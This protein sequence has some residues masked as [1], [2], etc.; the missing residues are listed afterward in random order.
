MGLNITSH[1]SDSE[2]LNILD[3]MDLMW[4]QKNDKISSKPENFVKKCSIRN[5]PRSMKAVSKITWRL[6]AHSFTEVTHKQECCLV[7]AKSIFSIS[8]VSSSTRFDINLIHEIICYS[9]IIFLKSRTRAY[10]AS[11][12]STRSRFY[13]LKTGPSGHSFHQDPVQVP[14][15]GACF[16]LLLE[17]VTSEI[18]GTGRLYVLQSNSN[19]RLKL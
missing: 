4:D 6:S 15:C 16:W 18:L 10:T 1:F 8:Y 14:D 17:K 19:P 2:I 5:M 3:N 12:R 9:V 11:L 13:D 7:L